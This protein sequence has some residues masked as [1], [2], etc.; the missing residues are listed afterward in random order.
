M[1]VN[2]RADLEGDCSV[3]DLIG[4]MRSPRDISALIS[5]L[6]YNQLNLVSEL[7]EC[8]LP[9]IR[10][11]LADWDPP[12]E[13]RTGSELLLERGLQALD[14][15]PDYFKV[16]AGPVCNKIMNPQTRPFTQAGSSSGF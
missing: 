11:I 12:E 9:E 16:P 8:N 3:R 15:V 13:S 5:I 1:S 14:Y 6:E 2:R 7:L 4:S 10:N